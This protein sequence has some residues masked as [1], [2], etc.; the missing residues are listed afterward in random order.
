VIVPDSESVMKLAEKPPI[1]D[2]AAELGLEGNT[3]QCEVQQKIDLL[4]WSQREDVQK[5]WDKLQAGHGLEKDAFEKATW[6]FLGFVLG[7]DYNIVISMSKAR[8][9]GGTGYI[10]SGD[11]MAEC[12][13]VLEK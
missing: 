7:R 11:A 12:F 5:A 13:D 2:M 8:K 3:R 10:D 4:K 1:A 6:G 9:L